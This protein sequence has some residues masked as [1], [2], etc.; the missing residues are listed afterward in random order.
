MK[1]L[2]EREILTGTGFGLVRYFGEQQPNGNWKL[3]IGGDD[4]PAGPEEMGIFTIKELY[5]EVAPEWL[6]ES[7]EQL[8][9]QWQE[10]VD[11]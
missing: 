3:W 7:A 11:R 6:V 8:W 1:L 2:A 10:F 9:H 5:G 4:F